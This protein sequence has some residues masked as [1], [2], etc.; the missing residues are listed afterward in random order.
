MRPCGGNR[1]T[2]ELSRAAIKSLLSLVPVLG[3]EGKRRSAPFHF[4]LDKQPLQTWVSQFSPEMDSAGPAT[5]QTDKMEN[6]LEDAV[7]ESELPQHTLQAVL[8]AESESKVQQAELLQRLQD[9]IE[10]ETKPEVNIVEVQDLQNYST[11]PKM[12][13]PEISPEDYAFL[14]GNTKTRINLAIAIAMEARNKVAR[15]IGTMQKEIVYWESQISVLEKERQELAFNEEVGLQIL[16]RARCTGGRLDSLQIQ[17]ASE[18][19][20]RPNFMSAAGNTVNPHVS[21]TPAASPTTTP[22]A[23]AQGAG[24]SIRG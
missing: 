4:P 22:R 5:T 24:A 18:S 21:R 10:L 23:D 6:M 15:A 3:L 12:Y 9:V 20:G 1:N 16:E 17:L 13:A 14:S 2:L 19:S 8:R 11:P 7:D